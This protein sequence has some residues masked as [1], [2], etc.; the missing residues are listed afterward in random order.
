[1]KLTSLVVGAVAVALLAGCGGSDE[2]G[3]SKDQKPGDSGAISADISE[4]TSVSV[5]SAAKQLAK[6]YEVSSYGVDG[7]TLTFTFGG[8][9]PDESRLISICQISTAVV[10]GIAAGE[11][12]TIALEYSDES[13]TCADL[14]T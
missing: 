14:L 12:D 4:G 9:K 5:Q 8:A 11:I 1:M 6:R 7:S 10:D 3:A 2:P 13:L